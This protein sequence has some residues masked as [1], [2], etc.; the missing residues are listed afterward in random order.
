MLRSVAM[1]KA[2][3]GSRSLQSQSTVLLEPLIIQVREA[4]GGLPRSAYVIV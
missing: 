2:K 1:V 4:L 3:P